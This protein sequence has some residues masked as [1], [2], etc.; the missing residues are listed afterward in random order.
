VALQDLKE[1]EKQ[2]LKVATVFINKGPN[3]REPISSSYMDELRFKLA[4]RRSKKTVL[5]TGSLES[6]DYY[7]ADLKD[8]TYL[9]ATADRSQILLEL[10][11]A[12]VKFQFAK[13][14]VSVDKVGRPLK[15]SNAFIRP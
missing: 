14:D 7:V 4:D 1:I 6:N 12:E 2:L 11:T 8:C 5:I 3:G 9:N 13:I 10:Y 15:L